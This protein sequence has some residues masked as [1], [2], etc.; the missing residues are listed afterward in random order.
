MLQ[1]KFRYGCPCPGQNAP[2]ISARE[3][4]EEDYGVQEVWYPPDEI[5]R[6][7]GDTPAVAKPMGFHSKG[8]LDQTTDSGPGEVVVSKA[9]T[10]ELSHVPGSYRT[11]VLSKI[12]MV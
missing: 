11:W 6:P 9:E 7:K 1:D 2:D 8:G 5:G 4:Q 10:S 12:S 3:F